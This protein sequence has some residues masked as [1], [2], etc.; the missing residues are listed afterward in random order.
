[1]NGM[2]WLLY[3]ILVRITFYVCYHYTKAPENVAGNIGIEPI[4]LISCSTDSKQNRAPTVEHISH[5][6]YIVKESNFHLCRVK[7]GPFH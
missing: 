3:R 2:N 7:T 6:W 4:S 1:M 5:N